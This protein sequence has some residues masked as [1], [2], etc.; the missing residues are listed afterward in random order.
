MREVD[1]RLAPGDGDLLEEHLGLDA[2]PRPPVAK[3]PLQRPRLARMEPLGVACPQHLQ[4]Q[5]R[6]EDALDVAD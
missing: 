4:H 2:V 5:L 3:A 1:R 6:F